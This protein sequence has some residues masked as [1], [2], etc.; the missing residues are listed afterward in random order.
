MSTDRISDLVT[1][2]YGYVIIK[3]NILFTSSSH[4]LFSSAVD[5]L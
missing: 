5:S 3:K 2:L 1:W 4:L